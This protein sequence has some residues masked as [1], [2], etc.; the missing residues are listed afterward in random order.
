MLGNLLVTVGRHGFT[1]PG[2]GR[3][4]LT[5]AAFLSEPAKTGDKV[6]LGSEG[7]RKEQTCS[8][9]QETTWGD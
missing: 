3:W 8:S 6:V 5:A 1:Q 9:I 2:V 4:A 7:W